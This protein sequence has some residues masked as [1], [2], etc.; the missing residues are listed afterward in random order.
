MCSDMLV[1]LLSTSL[2]VHLSRDAQTSTRQD[3]PLGAEG[4][5][6]Q[7]TDPI[8]LICCIATRVGC[9]LTA[10]GSMA[11]VRGSRVSRMP[12]DLRM[13]S[14]TQTMAG[15]SWLGLFI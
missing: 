2:R 8:V 10:R 7:S 1:L 5:G 15:V 12:L 11:L 4:F 13:L 14:Y 9:Q 3:V 6:I